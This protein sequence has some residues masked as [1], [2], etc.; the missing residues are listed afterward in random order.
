MKKLKDVCE[1]NEK[2]LRKRLINKL[3]KKVDIPYSTEIVD[4]KYSHFHGLSSIPYNFVSL[5]ALV[6]FLIEWSGE[7]K[8]KIDPG[9][10]LKVKKIKGEDWVKLNDVYNLI[11]RR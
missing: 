2:D 4:S 6:D 10:L 1:N 7:I 3:G 5:S 9:K 11:H 8:P